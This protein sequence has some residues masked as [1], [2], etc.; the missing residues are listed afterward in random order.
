MVL[1]V[2]PVQV[3]GPA[4]VVSVDQ[5]MDQGLVYFPLGGKTVVADDDA[6]RGPESA[7]NFHVAPL[8]VDESGGHS[9]AGL[10]VGNDTT[11]L[12]E[13]MEYL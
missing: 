13:V 6:V 11:V 10:D 5:L 1:A 12:S 9:A 2:G 3:F 8:Y 7:A 4:M